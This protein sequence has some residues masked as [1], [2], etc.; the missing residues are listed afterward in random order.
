MK[1]LIQSV[2]VAA[3]LAGSYALADTLELADGTLLE[4][5]LVG[6]SDDIVMFN[7]ADCTTLETGL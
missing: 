3:V 6:S 1:L 7:A 2:I 5:D 4:G